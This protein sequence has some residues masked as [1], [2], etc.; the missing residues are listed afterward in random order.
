M[1]AFKEQILT[2]V[3]SGKITAAEG[4][5]LL[6][7]A[8]APKRSAYRLLLN[9]FE[10]VSSMTGLAIGVAVVVAGFA[11]S[12][13]GVRFDG[14]LDVHPLP[15]VPSVRDAVLD[16]LVA[17]PLTAGIAW[18]VSLLL[19]RKGRFVDFL[20]MVG[21][22]RIP[23]LAMGLVA[24]LTQDHM[25]TSAADA[26]SVSPLFVMIL[27]AVALPA[28]TWNLV[29]FF[30]GFRTA[31]GTQGAKAVIGFIA[32]VVLAEVVSKVFLAVAS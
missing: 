19:A 3:S 8:S 29:L 24:A 1:S 20:G 17:W 27:L 2:M 18:L 15:T 16:Q 26:S 11:L 21:I 28:L 23:L 31:S 25:P 22:A 30:Q 13:L 10:Y 7:A 5:E 4:D 14:A 6:K 32:A 12:R 9:P